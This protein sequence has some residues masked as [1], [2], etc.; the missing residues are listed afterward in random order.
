MQ[1]QMRC[2]T[3][4]Y[5]GLVLTL[6]CDGSN[7]RIDDPNG[8]A[9]VQTTPA[10]LSKLVQFPSFALSRLYFGLR[11]NTGLIEFNLRKHEIKAIRV[12]IHLGLAEGS[13]RFANGLKKTSIFN[14]IVGIVAMI[15]GL[16][17][18]TVSSYQTATTG[19]TGNVFAGYFYFVLII[20]GLIMLISGINGFS[21][22]RA[23]RD[24]SSSRQ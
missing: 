16:L 3:K 7:L 4:P 6:T 21:R 9:I 12:M 13:P 23:M 15:G 2:R 5:R 11:L 8:N 20:V 14:I 17:N 19:N 1:I 18:K 24:A 22:L 10:D